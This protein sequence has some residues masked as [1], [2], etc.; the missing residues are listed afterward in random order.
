MFPSFVSDVILQNVHKKQGDGNIAIVMF[1]HEIILATLLVLWQCFPQ[2]SASVKGLLHPKMKINFEKVINHLPPCLSEPMKA[3]FISTQGCVLYV[4][5]R[6]DL[7]ANSAALWPS[8]HRKVYAFC[9]QGIISKMALHWHRGDVT[10]PNC[11][12]KSLFLFYF[13]TKSILVTS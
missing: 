4:D 13:H 5:L 3:S 12:I 2:A 6:S 9:V 7:N 8:W 1:S 10:V 11:W